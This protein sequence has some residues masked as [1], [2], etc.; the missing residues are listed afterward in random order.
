MKMLKIAKNLEELKKKHK[1]PANVPNMQIPM[2]EEFM[3]LQL[4]RETKTYVFAQKK[5]T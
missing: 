1:R 2:I 5:V 3:W 4:K